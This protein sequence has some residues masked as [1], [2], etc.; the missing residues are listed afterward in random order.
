MISDQGKLVLDTDALTHSII[1]CAF[2]VANELG[3]GFLEKVYENALR[4]EL[5]AAGHEVKQQTPL[6]VRYHGETVGEYVADL[7]VDGQVL[8]ELKSVQSISPA[9]Y[10]QCKNYLAATELDV[11]LLLNFGPTKL[12]HKRIL[13]NSLSD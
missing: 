9:H 1:G 13:R 3:S 2:R 6:V 12:E 4:I 8:I 11:C 10:A 5:E 7:L